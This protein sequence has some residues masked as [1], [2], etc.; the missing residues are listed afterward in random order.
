MIKVIFFVLCLAALY[1][2]AEPPTLLIQNITI[3]DGTGAT[4]QVGCVAFDQKSKLITNVESP[5]SLKPTPPTKV[6]DGTGKFIT[7][8]Y[9]DLLT[10]ICS[11]SAINGSAPDNSLRILFDDVLQKSKDER[12]QIY[13]QILQASLRSGVTT[14]IDSISSLDDVETL[15]QEINKEPHKYP[16]FHTLGP[17]IGYE[18]AHPY[19]ID[20]TPLK[21]FR[22]KFH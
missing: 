5:C 21:V 10:H 17:I 16:N 22:F 18:G 13:K 20:N 9:V 3:I 14:F 11:R 6:I 19:V 4:P 2:C 1:L 8:G 12:I 7:P 15:R